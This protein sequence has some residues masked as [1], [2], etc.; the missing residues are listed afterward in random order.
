MGSE[1]CI[2]DSLP[3]EEAELSDELLRYLFY[4]LSTHGSVGV[5]SAAGVAAWSA[6]L[7]F[8]EAVSR[9]VGL[10]SAAY[11]PDS[12]TREAVIEAAKTINFWDANGLHGVSNPSEKIPSPCYVIVTLQDGVWKRS[13]PSRPGELDCEESNLVTLEALQ[14]L[15]Q[16]DSS[17][18]NPE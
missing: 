8:Q 13:Y 11:D 18:E 15:T 3:I 12:L 1:M 2:R 6:G 5:P 7:L 10:D 14:G 4:L 17:R 9:A 16:E